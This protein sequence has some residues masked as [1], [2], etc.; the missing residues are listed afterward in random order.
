MAVEV[1]LLPAV[2]LNNINTNFQR[3]KV[4]LQDSVSRSG[5]LPNQMNADLDLNSNDLLNVGKIDAEQI[6]MDGVPIVDL[7]ALEDVVEIGPEI[8]AVASIATQVGV[9]SANAVAVM[10]VSNN[11]DNINTANANASNINIVSTNIASVNSAATNMAAIIAAPGEAQAAANSA[12]AAEQSKDDAAQSALDAAQSAADAEAAAA[13][14]D[15]NNLKWT[16]KGIGEFYVVDDSLPGVDIPPTNSSL[17]RFVKLTASDSYNDGVLEDEVVT[18]TA[19]LVVATAVISLSGSPLDGETISLINTERRFLRAGSAG[20]L[21]ED[22]MQRIT[23]GFWGMGG[24]IDLGYVTGGTEGAIGARSIPARTSYVPITGDSSP[25]V[26]NAGIIFDSGNST[27][28][29]V[30]DDET[31]PKNIG[32]T[33]YMRIK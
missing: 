3:V 8:V 9:V 24:A 23:G 13:T 30:S 28:A 25:G 6:Y 33:Y 19:P 22:A 5:A 15:L 10:N 21:E 4:A 31:R 11:I 27:G 29:R 18:G 17:F 16:S 26:R 32:V 12:L 14:I 20:T 7:P 2:N 1:N